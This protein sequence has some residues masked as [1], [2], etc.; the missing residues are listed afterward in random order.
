MQLIDG[1]KIAKEIQK[2]LK[3]EIVQIDGR[4]PGLAFIL[5]GEDLPSQTYVAMKKKGCQQIG[6]HS[7]VLSLPGDITQEGL[8]GEIDRLN[9]ADHIDGILVQQPFPKQIDTAAI[10]EAIDPN[11]DVDGFHPI[12]I[13]KLLLGVSGGFAACTPLGIVTLLEKSKI[14]TAGKHVVIVGRSNIVGKPLAALLMQKKQ[15]ANAT[16][17]IAHSGTQNLQELCREAD[18]L[19]AAL[20]S[21]HFITADR[22]KKGAVVIDVGINRTDKGLVGDVDFNNVKQVASAITP[23]PGGVGP[24]TIAMLLANTYESY[25]KRCG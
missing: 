13:G 18:I 19:V 25:K 16:V 15:G 7:E 3:Q 14:D 2:H 21:P 5:I 22:V 24:M 11:K 17:T 12:N 1:K 6:I 10:I 8:I 20:G 23:V 4:K 9:R